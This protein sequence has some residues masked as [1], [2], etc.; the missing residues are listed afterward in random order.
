MN[1]FQ[2]KLVLVLGG[3]ALAMA[4]LAF[5]LFGSFTE[6]KSIA[7]TYKA[8]LDST[9]RW[10]RADLAT[11]HPTTRPEAA[12]Q[13]L[14]RAKHQIDSVLSLDTTHISAHWNAFRDE[15]GM[16]DSLVGE[17]ILKHDSV[18]NQHW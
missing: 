6:L 14:E 17:E 13:A 4:G 11:A 5:V 7:T 18:Q 1:Q 8:N 2:K 9:A 10:R 16:A 15:I 12:K 3:L